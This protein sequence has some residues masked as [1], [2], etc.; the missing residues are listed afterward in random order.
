[1]LYARAY[2]ST[3]RAP[4]IR[5]GISMNSLLQ[6][7]Y[8][9]LSW[10]RHKAGIFNSYL[11]LLFRTIVYIQAILLGIPVHRKVEKQQLIAGK[12]LDPGAQGAQAPAIPT[13]LLPMQCASSSRHR[14]LNWLAAALQGLNRRGKKLGTFKTASWMLSRAHWT[15]GD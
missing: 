3:L 4:A 5:A 15:G 11:R 10:W 1:M 7:I 6:H 14:K 8:T 13:N 12:E 9:E 2:Y